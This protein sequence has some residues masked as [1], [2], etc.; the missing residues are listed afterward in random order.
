MRKSLAVTVV[1]AS[2]LKAQV[3]LYPVQPPPDHPPKVELGPWA[4]VSVIGVPIVC[5]TL[6]PAPPVWSQLI[7]PPVTFP[8]PPPRTSTA[9]RYVAL[10]CAGR[11]PVAISDPR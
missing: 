11:D 3:G 7:P 1:P 2:R 6:H 8:S 5:I 10:G 4:A 9:R